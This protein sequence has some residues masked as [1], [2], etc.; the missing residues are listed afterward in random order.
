VNEKLR[1]KLVAAIERSLLAAGAKDYEEGLQAT[2]KLIEWAHQNVQAIQTRDGLRAALDACPPMSKREALRALFIA[3]GLPF[4][5][6]TVLQMASKKVAATIA[7]PKGGR[8]P[9]I[10]PQK[11][12][13]VLD[14]VSALMRKGCTFEAAIERTARRF[15]SSE[16]TIERLWA[17]R[18]S[19]SE[20]ELMPEVTMDEAIEYITSGGESVR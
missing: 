17:R 6:R 2:K 18:G 5:F 4:L 1:E 13:E 11:T 20:D 10:P 7:A 3:A 16:R 8:P 15:G 12:G 19:I 9:A 14:C